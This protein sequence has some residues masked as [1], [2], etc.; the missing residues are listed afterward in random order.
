[1]SNPLRYNISNWDQ[2][3]KCRSNNSADLYITVDH[4]INDNRLEGTIIR[5][6]HSDFGLLFVCTINCKGT[7][8]TPDPDSGIIQ[9]FTTD[10]ILAELKKFGF[11]ITF[12]LESGLSG[13]QL[14]YLITVDALG[15]DKLRTLDVYTTDKLGNRKFS[16]Y[17][18]VFN[19]EKCPEWINNAFT[20]DEKSFLEALNNGGAMNLTNVSKTRQFDWTWLTYV[21]NIDDIIENNSYSE[22]D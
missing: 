20:V 15:F 18:V 11:D 10:Q 8:L 4:V 19:I 12:S 7:L 14:D 17:I 13:D 2:L 22:V 3:T 16:Q 9:E 1:M 6:T 5:V 21:A